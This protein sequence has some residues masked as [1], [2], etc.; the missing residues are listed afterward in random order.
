M[1]FMARLKPCPDTNPQFFSRLPDLGTERLPSFA[2][3][4]GSETRPH[5]GSSHL[6]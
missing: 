4:D 5:S 2:R 3:L 6:Q 1:R